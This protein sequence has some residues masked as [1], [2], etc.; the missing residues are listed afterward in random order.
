MQVCLGVYYYIH[1][2]LVSPV[3]Y[4]LTINLNGYYIT[5]LLI[6]DDVEFLKS[7]I[8]TALHPYDLLLM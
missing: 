6:I 1:L 8:S 4:G 2:H 3:I 7:Y 5:I